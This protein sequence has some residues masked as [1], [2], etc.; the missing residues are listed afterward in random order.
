[1]NKKHEKFLRL[2]EF[3]AN[4]FSKDRS[5]KVG[6]V[7]VGEDNEVLSLGYNGFPRGLDDN[8]ESRHERPEKYYWAEHAER[9]A[10]Y[11]ASRIGA[12]VKN[13]RIYISGLP[14]CHDCARGIIQ[15][16][17]KEV[18]MWDDGCPDRW[19]ESN[20]RADEMFKELGIPVYKIVRTN[21]E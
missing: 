21:K 19:G 16:G 9:N 2:A 1:M 12:S 5:T 6:A 4:E 15:A 18:Y 20:Q 11:N 7:I 10:L 8:V 3:V 17:V 14:P 13:G